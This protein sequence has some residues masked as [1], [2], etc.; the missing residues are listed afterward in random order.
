MSK[1]IAVANQ[2]GG[3][4]KTTTSLALADGLALLGQR[5]L[6]VDL[7]PQAS[8]TISMGVEADQLPSSVFNILLSTSPRGTLTPAANV[9]GHIGNLDLLPS[10]IDLAAAE[11]LLL[12]QHNR[13]R[14]LA[15]A[16]EPIR[17]N[18]DYIVID[19]PPSLGTLTLNA[20]TAAD[21]VLVPVA[22]EYLALRGLGLFME[23]FEDAKAQL[24]PNLKMLGILPTIVAKRIKHG[25]E[26][27]ALLAEQY[28]EHLLPFQIDRSIRFA[29]APVV[30]QSILSYQPDLPAAQTY[31]AL[32]EWVLSH[33]QAS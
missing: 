14:R 19:C 31:K 27:L 18:Y 4:G 22:P 25:T 10:T 1:V 33:D 5:V 15:N 28:K 7:D 8:L 23:T 9:V 21:Y 20:L 11:L 16:L 24:N 6:L 32:A 12:A 13:E 29:E 26:V 30:G 3:V 17:A 2:K